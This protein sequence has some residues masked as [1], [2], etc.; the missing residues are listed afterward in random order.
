MVS[1]LDEVA[2]GKFTFE[3]HE[4]LLIR[5]AEDPRKHQNETSEGETTHAGSSDDE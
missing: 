3:D 5:D 2:K 1:A 4:H